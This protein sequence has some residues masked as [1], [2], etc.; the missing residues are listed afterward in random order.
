MWFWL[1]LVA[2]GFVAWFFFSKNRAVQAQNDIKE[3][4]PDDHDPRFGHDESQEMMMNS[5]NLDTF[6]LMPKIKTSDPFVVKMV[7]AEHKKSDLV[8][9]WVGPGEVVTIQGKTISVGMLYVGELSTNIGYSRNPNQNDLPIIDPSLAIDD[10]GSIDLSGD[11]LSYW[12][13][14]GSISPSARAAYLEFLANGASNPNIGIGYV[15]LYYYGLERRLLVDLGQNGDSSERRTIMRE[16]QRLLVLYH[17]NRS[18][19]GY[20]LNLLA[21]LTLQHDE[22]VDEMASLGDMTAQ[23]ENYWVWIK[24]GRTVGKGIPISGQLALEWLRADQET[25]FRTPARR[26]EHEFEHLFKSRFSRF[27]PQGMIIKPNKSKLSIVYR[28]ASALLTMESFKVTSDWPDLSKI[29]SPLGKLREISDWATDELMPYSRLMGHDPD[30]AVTLP[31]LALLPVEILITKAKQEPLF[32]FLLFLVRILKG[33]TKAVIPSC[34]L[35]SHWPLA[36]E[37]KISKKEAITMAQLMD[38]SRIGMEPDLRFGHFGISMDGLVCLYRLKE[39]S[40]QTASPEYTSA[41]ILLHLAALVAGADGF[42]HHQERWNMEQHLKVLTGL[43][44]FER[45]RLDA[46]M[47]WLLEAQPGLEGMKKR[48]QRLE[49]EKARILCR[50]LSMIAMADGIV[51]PVEIDLLEKIYTMVHQD[52]AQV[53]QDLHEMQS[54]GYGPA[55]EELADGDVMMLSL[56]QKSPEV[57]TIPPAMLDIPGKHDVVLDM[58]RVR[59]IQ[60]QTAAV[61][62]LLVEVFAASEEELP[63]QWSEKLKPM[64]ELPQVGSLDAAHLQLFHVLLKTTTMERDD[65][66][67]RCRTLGLMPD[68]AIEVMN[69][70]AFA[71]VGE[72]IIVGEDPIEIDVQMAEEMM[73]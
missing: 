48:L 22:A 13:S 25:R 58:E 28:P 15:F 29:K 62:N 23:D 27:F 52:P 3:R 12:P 40:G 53:H 63:L 39:T 45:E 43:Q 57:Y 60:A 49:P 2:I 54:S 72:P 42:I 46:Q 55:S 61:H 7:H 73:A 50:F 10:A 11:N 26:L 67:A 32:S 41:S 64:P 70:A 66:D 56:Q 31:G 17:H 20:A 5:G 6:L 8:C 59:R 21:F 65:F 30:R 34:D 68:G 38:K 69:D 33:K 47:T 24:L 14:Y 9:R 37:G 16:I 19:R 1:L 36:E 51:R 44:P 71:K 35:L 4:E 18:F